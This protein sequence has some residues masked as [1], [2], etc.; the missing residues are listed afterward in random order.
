MNFLDEERQPFPAA[1]AAPRFETMS[2]ARAAEPV[3][4]SEA[5][6][7][8]SDILGDAER[9]ISSLLDEHERVLSERSRLRENMKETHE[10]SNVL[11]A[12]ARL[13]KKLVRDFFE[14]PSAENERALLEW[15]RKVL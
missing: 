10:R 15:S 11:L 8:L 1:R 3:S 12:E 13:A 6:R 9:R 4:D 5:G 7:R 14:F 2:S